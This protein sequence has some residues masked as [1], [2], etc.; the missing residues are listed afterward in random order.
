MN[1]VDLVFFN[2]NIVM[3]NMC[4]NTFHLVDFLNKMLFLTIDS[5]NNDSQNTYKR[6]LD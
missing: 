3:K 5:N 4:H 1:I 6:K 2:R